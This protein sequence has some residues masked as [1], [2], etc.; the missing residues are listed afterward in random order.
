MKHFLFLIPLVV[1][2]AA[3]RISNKS[4]YQSAN[5]SINKHPETSSKLKFAPGDMAYVLA[6]RG[7]TLREAP[8]VK[9][10]KTK[11]INHCDSVKI[12]GYDESP[13][14]YQVNE[15]KGFDIH[16]YWVKVAANA[17]TGYV[18]DGYLS[19]WKC[20]DEFCDTYLKK[21]FNASKKNHKVLKEKN[22][23][24]TGNTEI[25]L[26]LSNG[27]TYREI[28]TY[29]G[30]E[31]TMIIPDS[32]IS[33]EEAFLLFMDKDYKTHVKIE[34]EIDDDNNIP[35]KPK[36]GVIMY[37]YDFVYCY[38]YQKKDKI[39]IVDSMYC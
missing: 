26:K 29:G 14:A 8:G 20:I 37:S 33:L 11:V 36:R 2:A 30:A 31:S 25:D 3:F 19:S 39:I 22:R 23:R 38:I 34:K 7:L 18:F 15:F 21:K 12:I 6:E 16:G 4:S 13:Q 27:I 28:G 32:L 35:Y 5:R 1:I 17:D 9:S 10:K 24:K